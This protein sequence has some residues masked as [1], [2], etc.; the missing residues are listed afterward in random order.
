MLHHK[1]NRPIPGQLLFCICGRKHCSTAEFVAG[2][3]AILCACGASIWCRWNKRGEGRVM[4]LPS[5]ATKKSLARQ[6][7]FAEFL[8]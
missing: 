7:T 2:Q 1:D 4:A 8:N 6:M 5:E 3:V